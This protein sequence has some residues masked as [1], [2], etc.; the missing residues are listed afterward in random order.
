[1]VFPVPEISSLSRC[2]TSAKLRL[3]Y[4]AV[5]IEAKSIALLPFAPG[6]ILAIDPGASAGWALF[7]FSLDNTWWMLNCG[8]EHPANCLHKEFCALRADVC[9][10]E[11]PNREKQD[12]IKR[13]NDLYK[14]ALRAGVLAASTTCGHLVTVSP[15]EWKGSVPKHIHNKRC[16]ERLRPN[17][18]ACL[19][20]VLSRL[21][22]SESNNVIDAIGLG[23]WACGRW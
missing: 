3:C 17:E 7:G 22:E 12:T 9:I 11:L 2:G 10:V 5:M 20:R 21:P 19:R 14:T 6:S 1:M 18:D 23:L 8:L 13:S 15:H 16:L 4:G